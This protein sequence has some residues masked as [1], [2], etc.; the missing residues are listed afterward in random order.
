MWLII[1]NKQFFPKK[2]MLHTHSRIQT[3]LNI[4]MEH[5]A[6]IVNNFYPFTI[7]AKRVILDS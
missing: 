5:F 6:E 3:L 4:L 2:Q 7:F 1:I